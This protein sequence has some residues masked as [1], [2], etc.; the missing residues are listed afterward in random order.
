[1][2]T[3]GL[4]GRETDSLSIRISSTGPSS[5]TGS[6]P[7]DPTGWSEPRDERLG[8]DSSHPLTS[9]TSRVNVQRGGGGRPG[10]PTRVARPTDDPQG[11]VRIKEKKTMLVLIKRNTFIRRCVLIKTTYREFTKEK[12]T[13]FKPIH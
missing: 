9:E 12:K 5:L 1:M 8:R 4:K 11:P 13:S 6:T 10:P 3:C 2:Q 7:P